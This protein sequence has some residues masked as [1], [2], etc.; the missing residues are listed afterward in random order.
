MFIK[1]PGITILTDKDNVIIQLSNGIKDFI[2]VNLT[3]NQFTQALSRLMHTKC[4]SI[5][6]HNL[7]RL[8]KKRI[9]EP[10]EFKV[11]N[12]TYYRSKFLKFLT[13]YKA[14]KIIMKKGWRISLYFG[15]QGSY[16]YKSEETWARTQ[17]YKYVEDD[18]NETNVY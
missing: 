12:K 1:D 3:P 8:N 16:F 9:S 18:K 14:N 10:I 11:S 17:I 5:E 6:T 7:E 2:T 13:E 4:T 15:S